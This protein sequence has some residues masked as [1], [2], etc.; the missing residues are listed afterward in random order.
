MRY[1]AK[2]QGQ[3]EA[4]PVDIEPAGENR[5][6]LTHGGKTFLVDALTLDHGAVSMLVDGTSYGVEFDEQG[7]EVQVLVRGQVTR[8][9]VADERRLRLR[10]GSAA[11]SVEGKQLIAAPMPGKVVKVLVKLGDEVKEGQGLVVVEA[12]KMEN[13]LKSPKAGKVVELPAKEGTAVEINAK[14]V[15]VE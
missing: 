10:A 1:F 12:M 15:V 7:D 8:I 4:V 13:E 5:F 2:L 11:F 6:K 14:L 3:K 9:D